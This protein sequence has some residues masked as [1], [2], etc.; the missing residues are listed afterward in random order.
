[1]QWQ[2][3]AHLCATGTRQARVINKERRK[4]K[5]RVWTLYLG[6]IREGKCLSQMQCQK[7]IPPTKNN[8]VIYL[9]LGSTQLFRSPWSFSDV[10]LTSN[11]KCAVIC[12]SEYFT[13]S[14]EKEK[15]SV[16]FL[17]KTQKNVREKRPI[18]SRLCPHIFKIAVKSALEKNVTTDL[19]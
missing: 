7:G 10:K 11:L 19:K 4:Q 8:R 16:L 12:S 17:H 13:T 14:L 15:S 9:P 3:Y 6:M 2:R 1:M 5:H 18:T